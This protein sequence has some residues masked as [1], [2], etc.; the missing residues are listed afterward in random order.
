[1]LA[2][3]GILMLYWTGEVVSRPLSSVTAAF[4]AHYYILRLIYFMFM[5]EIFGKKIPTVSKLKVP[6]VPTST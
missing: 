1:M 5:L 2:P 4:M 3:V 6:L